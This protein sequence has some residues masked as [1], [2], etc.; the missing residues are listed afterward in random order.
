MSRRL[1]VNLLF[2]LL[3]L[4]LLAG[5]AA[6][7]DGRAERREASA[8][9]R[10]PPVG[11]L[12][13]LD[14]GTVVHVL[15]EGDGPDVVL[16]HGASGNLRDFTMSLTPLLTEDF[17]VIAF[18]RPGFG[19]TADIGPRDAS[20]LAQADVMIAAADKLGVRD[21]VVLGHS[22]GGAVAMGW[23]L[24]APDPP[25]ALTIVSGT[26]HPWPG[27]LGVWY[28]ITTGRLGTHLLT[29]L[30]AAFAPH[31]PPDSFVN[32]IFRPQ[33]APDGYLDH[34]GAGLTLR[35]ATL[36]ANAR[37]IRALNDQLAHMAPHY[38][39]LSMPL[40]IVHGL[41]DRIVP[42]DIHGVQLAAD[43]ADASL[44]LLDGVGHMPH[45]SNPEQIAAAVRRA[46]TRA[47]LL[48]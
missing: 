20:P 2:A 9:A 6:L 16:L 26:T 36:R 29:P 4:G 43:V 17:R 1:A 22:Y 35:R 45:H 24:R 13:T 21:P 11:E 14:D 44:T 23:A 40:E 32:N 10:W 41:E 33:S 37:Q 28:D 46:A 39:R 47:G 19:H 42:P 25:A 3:A 18:D 15:V 38:G 34:I 5:C 27:G 8:E 12:V 7:V 31:G 48:P 30:A